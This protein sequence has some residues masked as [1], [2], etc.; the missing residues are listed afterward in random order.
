M[1]VFSTLL[2]NED[3]GPLTRRASPLVLAYF[4]YT[5]FHIAS[6]RRREDRSGILHPDA[7]A[8]RSPA[9]SRPLR[10]FLS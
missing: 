5:W 8:G 3:R 4:S 7:V 1:F 9:E 2:N 6:G 10:R